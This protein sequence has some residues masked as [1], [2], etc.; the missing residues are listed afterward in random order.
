MTKSNHFIIRIAFPCYI[1]HSIVRQA[2]K[3]TSTCT[4][5]PAGKPNIVII[6]GDDIGQSNISAYSLRRDGI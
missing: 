4:C 1:S 6:W 2:T 3:K 5:T